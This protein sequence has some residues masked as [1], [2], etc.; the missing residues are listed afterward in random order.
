MKSNIVIHFLNELHQRYFC[1]ICLHIADEP[2]SCGSKDGCTGVFCFKCL[3]R[4]L[5]S[6]KTCPLCKF[7]IDSP[8]KNNIIK[9]MIADE[10]I[11]CSF[12]QLPQ[13]ENPSKT[14]TTQLK[15]RSDCQWTGPFKALEAHLSHSCS[16]APV[17]CTNQ[18]CTLT[19][20][21][22]QLACHLTN[23]CL[24]RSIPC[25]HCASPVRVGG[26]PVHLE[27]CGKVSLTCPDCQA[28]YL[29]ENQTAHDLA[30]LERLVKCPFACYGC[31]DV[32]IRKDYDQHQIDSAVDHA[33][34]LVMELKRV[35]KELIKVNTTI[36]D[37][38][39][40]N[41]NRSLD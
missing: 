26:Q 13:N 38:T 11:Y 15:P 24:F 25:P 12:S 4:S 33:N 6:N 41:E 39:K 16:F 3:M 9:E 22:S 21:R 32:V 2:L 23:D 8:Q 1:G 27:V 36:S 31:A 7:V 14:A 18:G 5:V 34:H 20:I 28:T 40:T 37:H 10:I 30:C 29:R 19:P 17:P 35:N